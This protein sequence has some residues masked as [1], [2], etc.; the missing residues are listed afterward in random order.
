MK[1]KKN[2]HLIFSIACFVFAVLCA[3]IYGI[4]GDVTVRFFAAAGFTACSLVFL[5]MFM[6]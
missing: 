4:S 6:V 3:V 1:N 5:K 2:F